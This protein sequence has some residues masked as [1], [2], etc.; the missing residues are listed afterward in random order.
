MSSMRRRRM[1]VDRVRSYSRVIKGR[2]LTG[3]NSYRKW[4]RRLSTIARPSGTSSWR[5]IHTYSG[6]TSSVFWRTTTA[7]CHTI[8]DRLHPEESIILDRSPNPKNKSGSRT[9]APASYFLK[10]LRIDS[11]IAPAIPSV[12][13]VLVSPQNTK[14]TS[15]PIVVATA[16]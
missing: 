1:Q 10:P 9:E 5:A 3:I 7:H 13:R 14:K 12:S 2:G 11:L 8:L 6:T 15:E 16:Y 4:K